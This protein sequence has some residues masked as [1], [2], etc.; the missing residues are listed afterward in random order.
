MNCDLLI[1]SICDNNA[2]HTHDPSID[3]M[4][5][6]LAEYAGSLFASGA[7]CIRL[8]KNVRRIA[9]AYGMEVEMVVFPRHISLG[10]TDLTSGSCRTTIASTTGHALSFNINT[11]LSRLSWDIADRR[12]DFTQGIR[13]YRTIIATPPTNKYLV[14]VL[15]SLANASFCRLFGG[16]IT[17]MAVV[18]VATLTG[19]ALKQLLTRRK[20]DFRLTVLLCA[21]VSAIIAACDNLF[22]LGTTPQLAIGTSVLYLVPGI[23]FINSFCDMI[24]SHYICAFGRLM[25]AIVI[26]AC[27]SVGLWLAMCAMKIPMF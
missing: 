3:E 21:F 14:V 11:L 22:G 19:F 26:T 8:E 17:A 6:F 2:T 13:L 1:S 12:I 24:D 18:F 5:T 9:R 27:L 4:A 16:D 15:A 20:V 10:I 7:T 25:N 23:P